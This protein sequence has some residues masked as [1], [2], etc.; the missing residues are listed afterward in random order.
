MFTGLIEEVG[1]LQSNSST[2]AGKQL[3]IETKTLHHSMVVGDSVSING[4][5][6]TVVSITNNSFSVDTIPE[7]LKK[8]TL[9]NLKVGSK[10]NLELALSVKDNLLN[11][12]I[13][14][15]FVQGHIDAIGSIKEIIKHSSASEFFISYPTEYRK[16][17]AYT[18]SI[19]IDGVS[20]TIAQ[21][22]KNTFKVA[23]I[24]HTISK[25]LFKDYIVGANVNIEFDIIGKYVES[26]LLYGNS[27]T[28][29]NLNRFLSQ[30]SL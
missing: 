26:M 6:Q 2:N 30:P 23:L 28:K 4:A 22:T 18:G 9:G 24:P 20:L 8:T 19:T 5:C 15:H 25:T 11:S 13:G 29:D 27:Q 1:I 3:R 17:L 16:Y 10:V 12:R 7:T 14:G 21:I